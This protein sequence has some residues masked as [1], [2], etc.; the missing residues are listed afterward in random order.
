MFL[1]SLEEIYRKKLQKFSRGNS[2]LCTGCEDP[3][4]IVFRTNGDASDMVR[5][6]EFPFISLHFHYQID[7]GKFMGLKY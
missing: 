3:L 2:K 1:F 4:V 5:K 7:E 6:N